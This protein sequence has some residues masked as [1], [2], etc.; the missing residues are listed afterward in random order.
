LALSCSAF[1]ALSFPRSAPPQAGPG[2]VWVPPRTLS[3]GE[4]IPG[5]WRLP[6][7]KGFYW[8]KGKEDEE[9]NWIP[10]HWNPVPG[11]AP[12]NQAWAPGYWNGT[13][14]VEGYW[15]PAA[16]P[17]YIW[18]GPRWHGGGWEKG[19]WRAYEGGQPFRVKFPK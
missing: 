15:R 1:L 14:W 10:G 12:E 9:G 13:I 5:Y 16:R 8:V 4:V 2:S 18:I 11:S 7:R 19:H 3:S 6:F 17:G